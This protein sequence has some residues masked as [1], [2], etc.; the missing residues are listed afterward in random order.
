MKEYK[1]R[2]ADKILAEKLDAM[3][4]VLIEGPKYCGK[5][6]LA[7]QQAKSILAMSDPDTME[8]NIAMANTNSPATSRKASFFCKTES[9]FSAKSLL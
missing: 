4:A 5:T 9:T 1:A 2:I 6:T 8:Q 3:G 7:S